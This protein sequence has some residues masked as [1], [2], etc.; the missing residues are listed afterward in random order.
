M[1][2]ERTSDGTAI[3]QTEFELLKPT[4]LQYTWKRKIQAIQLHATFRGFNCY[5]YRAQPL[6]CDGWWCEW[7]GQNQGKNGL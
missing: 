6:A 3:S 7:T 2:F 1:N 4:K 5:N